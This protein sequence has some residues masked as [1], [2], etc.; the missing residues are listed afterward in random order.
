M[1]R[2]YSHI[3]LDERRRLHQLIAA[4]LPVNEIARL[5]GSHRSTVCR[6]MKRNTFHGTRAA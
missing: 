6:E 1:E 3:D 4:K 2:T 5:L